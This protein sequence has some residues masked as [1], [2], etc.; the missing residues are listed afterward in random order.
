MAILST[1]CRARQTG[2]TRIDRNYT[3][4]TA[5]AAGFDDENILWLW[6]GLDPLRF[7]LGRDVS[8]DGAKPFVSGSRPPGTLPDILLH[9]SPVPA[10]PPEHFGVPMSDDPEPF[11]FVK[12]NR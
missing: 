4:V 5:I 8:P 11:G 1:R 2:Q 12:V 10:L 6:R 7:I 3:D 9:P